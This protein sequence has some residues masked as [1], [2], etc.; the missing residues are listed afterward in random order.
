MRFQ[1]LAASAIHAGAPD[2]LLLQ[3]LRF[4]LVMNLPDMDESRV[5]EATQLLR[6]ATAIDGLQEYKYLSFVETL[7]W[8]VMEMLLTDDPGADELQV[9]EPGADGLPV[10]EP[11]VEDLL[12][13]TDLSVATDSDPEAVIEDTARVSEFPRVLAR[14]LPQISNAFARDFSTVDPRINT[15]LASAFDIVQSLEDGPPDAARQT[16]LTRELADAVAQLVLLIPD[17]DFYFDQPV[18][19]RIAEE[20]NICTSIAAATGPGGEASLSREQFDRCLASLAELSETLVRR[21][22]LAGDPDGPFGAEQLRREL[23][24]TPWQRINYALG[25]LHER[26]RTPCQPPDE[27]LPNPLEWAALVTV[28]AWFAEQSPVYFQTPANEALVVQM[29]Q[30]GMELLATME[31]Q[32]DCFSGTGKGLGDPVRRSL[33]DYQHTL[34]DLAAGIRE[35]ELVFREERLAPGADIVLSE[36]AHQ[37]TAYRPDGLLIGPCQADNV[38]EMSGELEATRALIGLFPGHYLVADQAGLGKIEICYDNMQW[39]RRRSEPIRP[40][41]PNVAD[42]F[43]H[44][45]FDLIGRYVE[46]GQ[47]TNVFGSNFISPEEYHY[48]FAAASDEVL[49]DSC[50]SKWIGTKIVTNLRGNT[51]FRVVP[52]RLTY[53]ASARSQPSQ[54]INA[55]WSRG[56]EWRDWFVTGLG[57]TSFEFQQDEKIF[58]RINQQLKALYQA[59]ESML[60]S[61]LLRPP[62]RGGARQSISLFDQMIAVDTTKAL[63][64]TQMALFFPDPLIDSDELRGLLEGTGALIDGPVLR[65]FREGNVPVESINSAGATRL[66]EFRAKWNR[67]PKAARR[68]GSVALS[69]AHA[70]VRLN[71]L[72]QAFFAIPPTPTEPNPSPL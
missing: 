42:Y 8:V 47:M 48:L 66:A 58:A 54:I 69:V 29:K 11:L 24:L 65:R 64:R 60:Y 22:E 1:A 36:D 4:T 23:K 14:L 46:D 16:Y 63:L 59:E 40:D 27:P 50:A 44:L 57:V 25:Y 3:Q 56:A 35:T 18:R 72:Y 28:L 10:D 30:Q 55:N 21:A 43:G 34:T 5:R 26:N 45:S 37:K 49:N 41:D 68:T 15:I 31:Q 67:Q 53:L 19:R 7:I 61:A 17:M 13:A 38:C 33:S 71:A 39:V 32:V 6:M 52:D 12:V 62:S 9:D 70:I 20:I 2:D 51:S